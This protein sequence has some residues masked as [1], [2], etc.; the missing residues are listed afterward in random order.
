MAGD[1]LAPR[2]VAQ[3]GAVLPVEFPE[4]GVERRGPRRPPERCSDPPRDLREEDRVEPDVRIRSLRSLAEREPCERVQARPLR[5]P[6]RVLHRGLK[7][8][9]EVEHEVGL[10]QTAHRAR[11]ELDVVRLGAGRR[12]VLDVH[13]RAPDRGGGESERIEGGDDRAL[14]LR[15]P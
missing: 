7:V 10:L 11:R 12:Q 15:G 9:R 2:A 8:M 5:F 4:A 14:T 13:F 1:E 6:G 3:A